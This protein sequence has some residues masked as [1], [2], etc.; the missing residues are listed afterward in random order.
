MTMKL[1]EALDRIEALELDDVVFAKRPWTLQTESEIGRLDDD[2]GV[3]PGVSKR[4]FDYFIDVPTALEVL[5]VLSTRNATA[6]DKRELLLHYAEFDA[7]PNWVY[8][9][10]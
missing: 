4:G 5:E 9:K 3:P 7:Y 8:S 10:K 1:T 6:S 2:Y